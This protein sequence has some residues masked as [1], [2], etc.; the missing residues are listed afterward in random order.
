M[1]AAAVATL[2]GAG[3]L[4][5]AGCATSGV[6]GGV[7]R[8]AKGYRVSVPGDGWEVA[9]PGEADLELRR[10]D[11]R[12][13]MLVHATCTGNPP[14]RPLPLLARHATFGLSER[15]TVESAERPV[16][17]HPGLRTVVQGRVGGDPVTVEAVTVKG[18]ACVYDFLY[19]AP[20]PHFEEGRPDFHRFVESFTVE[21]PR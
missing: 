19:V 13:G 9:A 10:T 12:A 18:P 20:P 4:A 5:A 16:R 15:V 17:G 14:R 21:P 3:C 11:P 8:S 2:L 7:F 1:R 6:E